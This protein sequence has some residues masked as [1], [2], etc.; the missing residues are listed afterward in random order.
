MKIFISSVIGDFQA[1]RTAAAE[2]AESLD[3]EIIRAEDFA[4]APSSPQIACLSGVRAADAVIV[5][6]GGRYGEVQ[7]SGKSATHEEF[8]EATRNR[9]VFVFVQAGVEPEA[10]QSELIKEARAWATGHYSGKFAD[11][12]ELR[13][14]VTRAL[15]RWQLSTVTG[16]VE[17]E[18]IEMRALS[19]LPDDDRYRTSSRAAVALSVV[20]APRQ[21]ILR[22]SELEASSFHRQLEQQALFGNPSIFETR[23]GTDAGIEGHTLTLKQDNA[24]LTLAEDSSHLLVLPLSREER[25]GLDAIIEEDVVDRIRTGLQFSSQLLSTIDQT[26]RLSSVGIAVGILNPG[27]GEWRTRAEHERKPNSM[28][29]SRMDESPV[30]AV[31]SPAHRSRAAFRQQP[32]VIAQD[33]A[34]LLR[35]FFRS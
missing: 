23:E 33:L 25:R 11:A 30:R 28:Q 27:H 7:P 10:R 35:R 24:Y 1:F 22:P 8:E 6:L 14:L 9:Q 4:A 26:E 15:H 12:N 19:G 32:E 20:G 3:H 16:Q 2:A 13:T 31:L 21:S 17:S 34:V 18:E 29:M 5:L